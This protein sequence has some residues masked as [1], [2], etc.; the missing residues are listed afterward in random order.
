MLDKIRSLQDQV[1]EVAVIVSDTAGMVWDF[2]LPGI[3]LD[4]NPFT[5]YPPDSF[6]APPASGSAG[7][8]AMIIVPCSMGTLGRIASGSAGDLMSRA[9]D[10]ML[11]E[12]KKLVLVVRETPYNRIHIRNMLEITDAGGIICPASPGFYHNPATIEELCSPV[13]ARAL[14]LAGIDAGEPGFLTP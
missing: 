8:D 13:V 1:A 5:R 3:P 6:F 11:K 2:E 10:V 12:R 9:A 4:T 7:Y 14:S